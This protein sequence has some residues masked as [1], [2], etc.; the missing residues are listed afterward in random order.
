VLELDGAREVAVEFHSLSKTY[1]MTGWRLG[2][3]AGSR[4][5]VAALSRVKTFMDTGAFLAVQAAGVAALESWESWVPGNVATFR[6]RRDAAVSGL[7]AAG[8]DVVP[9]RA[10]MYVWVPVPGRGSSEV[11]ARTALEERGVVVLPG[12]ALGPG[13]EGFFRIALTVPEA[14]LVLAA[15]R[16]ADLLQ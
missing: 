11:F 7:A 4:A 9:P 6:R 15:E 13:G 5:V 8:F 10:T 2:W 3:V 14:R 1:N 12:S 16:L